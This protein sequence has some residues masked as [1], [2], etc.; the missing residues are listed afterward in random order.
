[1]ATRKAASASSVVY[2]RTSTRTN[3]DKGGKKRG[4]DAAKSMAQCRGDKVS[5]VIHDVV[6]GS[7]PLDQR[8]VL[9]NLLTGAGKKKCR[10]IYVE[11]AR[12]IARDMLVVEQIYQPLVEVENTAS[13]INHNN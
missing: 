13:N 5:G 10:K 8:D 7:K 6:S 4:A 12:D 3:K 9:V 2:V 11:S 1:M